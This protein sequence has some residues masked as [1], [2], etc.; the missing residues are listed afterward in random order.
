MKWITDHLWLFWSIW[1]G[2]CGIGYFAIFETI[3]IV[4]HGETF[5]RFFVRSC[6]DWPPLGVLWGVLFGALTVHFFWV[7]NNPLPTG[8]G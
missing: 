2:L 8:T 7:W 1:L 3:A 6:M 4:N 5:S